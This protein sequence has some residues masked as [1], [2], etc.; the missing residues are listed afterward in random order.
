MLKPVFVAGDPHP[1]GWGDVDE[2]RQVGIKV[3]P[4]GVVDD[5]PAAGIA[6]PQLVLQQVPVGVDIE[7]G[8]VLVA[9]QFLGAVGMGRGERELRGRPPVLEIQFF[10]D[11]ANG[12]GR[13]RGQQR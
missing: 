11:D 9:R 2:E 3:L 1:A 6:R 5:V 7:Q 8:L 10:L 13:R 12:V 4:P